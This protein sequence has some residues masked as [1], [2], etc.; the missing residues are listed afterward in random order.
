TAGLMRLWCTGE[1]S[2]MKRSKIIVVWLVAVA[3][4]LLV[5]QGQVLAAPQLS[6]YLPLVV[7][8]GDGRPGIHSFTANPPAIQP[9]D[10]STLTWNVTGATVLS[11]SPGVGTVT[12]TQIDVNPTVT[13]E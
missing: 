3:A 10:T 12:G 13:T 7:K 6:V 4:L 9:G 5:A 8:P 2:R 11:I 1:E